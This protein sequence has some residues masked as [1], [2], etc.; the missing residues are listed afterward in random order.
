MLTHDRRPSLYARQ[1]IRRNTIRSPIRQPSG[2]ER[3]ME[4]YPPIEPP[5]QILQLTAQVGGYGRH[6]G[7]H[8]IT[9]LKYPFHMQRT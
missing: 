4:R 7:K 1:C 6:V 2:E 5:D 3:Q 8:T 9:V